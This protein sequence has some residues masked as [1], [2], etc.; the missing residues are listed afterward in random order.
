MADRRQVLRLMLLGASGLAVPAGLAAACGVPTGGHAI[1]DEAGPSAGAGGASPGQGPPGPET[2]IDQVDLVQ[3][4]LLAVAGPLEADYQPMLQGSAKHFMTPDFAD[5]WSQSA[6][7]GIQI[8]RA[9]SG[10]NPRGGNFSTFVDVWLEQLGQLNSTGAVILPATQTSPVAFQFEV[11]SNPTGPGFRIANITASDRTLAN[12]M[13]LLDEALVN[14]S[15]FAAQMVYYWPLIGEDS[16]VPDLRYVPLSG[17][18]P[19]VSTRIITDLLSGAPGWL[20]AAPM[21]GMKLAGSN[22]YQNKDGSWEVDLTGSGVDLDKLMTQIRWSVW[23]QTR[24]TVQL[25]VGA[26]TKRV[27]GADTGFLKSNLADAASI[28][29]RPREVFCIVNGAVQPLDRD[30]PTPSV[31]NIPGNN[32]KVKWAGL[33][34]DKRV[35]AHVRDDGSLWIG[36]QATGM[37]QQVGGV[38]KGA[39]LGR[40]VWVPGTTPPRLLVTVDKG[41]FTADSIHRQLTDVTPSGGQGVRAF[42]V[43]PDGRRIALIGSDDGAVFVAALTVAEDVNVGIGPPTRIPVPYLAQNA[44]AMRAIAWSRIERVVVAGQLPGAASA[45]GA[46][47]VTV[48]GVYAQLM[49]KVSPSSDPITHLV[50]FPPSPSEGSTV[51]GRILGQATPVKQGAAPYAIEYRA[52][53]FDPLT[54]TPAPTASGSSAH[55]AAPLALFFAD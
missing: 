21:A 15:L 11:K 23:P 37:Y 25:K 39:T 18:D 19:K 54:V 48:D 32:S 46:V 52:G 4:Y 26:Q 45:Y 40:P 9:T 42:S 7:A 30:T 8:V 24:P 13:L 16:L 17:G 38:P 5:K 1:V 50:A 2:A 51:P 33:T 53:K 31:L 49:T 47:E 3:K 10:F 29:G 44:T 12:G 34:R 28:D 6:K 20:Q 43:A 27:D 22:V 14:Q 55:P 41:L 36:L 35:V